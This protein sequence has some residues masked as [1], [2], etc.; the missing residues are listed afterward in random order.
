EQQRTLG[1]QD[2]IRHSI[3]NFKKAAEFI[4]GISSKNFNVKWEGLDATN[5]QQND[6][7]LAGELIKMR[8]Q[9]KAAKL[10][11]EQRFWMNDG[12]AQFSQIVRKHQASLPEL[13]KE[14]T[15]YLSHYL[16][17]QQGSLF[18]YND[19]SE[20]DPFLELTGSYATHLKNNTNNRIEIGEGLVGQTYKDGEPQI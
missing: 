11:D 13:C 8:D 5:I 3:N 9:M 20:G 2:T 14:A 1:F 18:I 16:R 19:E 6:H 17:A 15:S 7:T 4:R 12:L 10:E